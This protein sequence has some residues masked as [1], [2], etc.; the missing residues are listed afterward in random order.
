MAPEQ[1]ITSISASKARVGVVI[2]NFNAGPLLAE[3]VDALLR[4][5]VVREVVISDNAS[6]DDSLAILETRCRQDGRVKVIKNHANLGFARGSNV[7]VTAITTPY[8]LFLNPDCIVGTGALERMM[9]F[10]DAAPEVGMSG[11]IVRD[12]DGK[13]QVATRRVI[14]N[15]WIALARVLYIERVWP[16]LLSGKQ[17]NRAGTPLP[18]QPVEVEAISGAFMLV[19]RSALEK[20]GPMDEEYFLHCEDLDWFERF[21]R[22]GSPIYLVPDANAV[23]YKG[24]CSASKPIAVLWHKHKGMHRFFRKFQ[25][26]RYPLPFSFL[27]LSGI[28]LHFAVMGS[29]A[30]LR[31]GLGIWLRR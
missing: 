11:C 15:P 21:H 25:F 18:S 28:W 17:L 30:G 12:P 16:S 31:Q 7:A 13:E 10:M 20:V 6:T 27:V 29:V 4:S 2:V 19:R 9:A 26:R 22:C 1:A 23:H 5:H 24:V 14:P 3:C 8:L